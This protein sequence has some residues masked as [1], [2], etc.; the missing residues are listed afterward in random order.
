MNDRDL[1]PLDEVEASA[2]DPERRV[3]LQDA[4]RHIEEIFASDLEATAV[5]AALAEG[6][7]PDET[8]ELNGM[9]QLQYRAAQKRIRR[10][11]SRLGEDI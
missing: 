9:T 4:I 2:I 11:L 5:L 6:L 8:C 3:L 7:S 1:A 10:A